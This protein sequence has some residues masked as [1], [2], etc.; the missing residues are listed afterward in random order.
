MKG[1]PSVSSQR[2]SFAAEATVLSD[3]PLPTSVPFS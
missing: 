1:D 2:L 3:N